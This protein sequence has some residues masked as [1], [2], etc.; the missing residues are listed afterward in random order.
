MPEKRSTTP[1]IISPLWFQSTIGFDKP[2][3]KKVKK[4]RIEKKI[5][6]LMVKISTLI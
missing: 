1:K 5:V 6:F 4:T 2:M 3:K